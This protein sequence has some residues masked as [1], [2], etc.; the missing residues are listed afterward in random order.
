MWR[1]RVWECLQVGCRVAPQAQRVQIADV[2]H[3][4]VGRAMRRVARDTALGFDHRMFKG[5]WTFG[6][7]VALRTDRVLISRRLQLR[8]FEG[9]MRIVTIAALQ[10]AFID[11]VMKRLRERRFYIGVA[12]VA[13]L[14]LRDL[15]QIRLALGGMRAVTVRAAHLGM[16]MGGALEVGM[17]SGMTG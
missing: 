13:Q 1:H 10:Q 2:Q 9:A 12:G 4:R 15:E 14:R 16:A 17:R 3:A 7:G 8:P 5:E 6:L 11:F